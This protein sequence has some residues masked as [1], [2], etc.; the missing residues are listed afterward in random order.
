[1]P[2]D[3]WELDPKNLEVLQE[4]PLGSGAFAVVYEGRLS[5]E[6]PVDKVYPNLNLKATRNEKVG[7]SVSLSLYLFQVAVKTPPAY[8]DS[9]TRYAFLEEIRFMKEL[10]YHSH[11]LGMFGCQTIGPD[12]LMV[13]E[14]CEH[15]DLQHFLRK[16][17]ATA[18]Q[19]DLVSISWQISDGLV[20]ALS[21]LDRRIV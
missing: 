3:D 14:Y 1:M 17:K 11:L 8:A 4:K 15:G 9:L 19:K 2:T 13:L 16:N 21:F 18:T 20:K 10:G 7:F 12:A 5:G 6:F